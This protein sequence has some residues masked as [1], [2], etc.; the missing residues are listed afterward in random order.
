VL[1]GRAA[2]AV[3]APGGEG[4]G[5]APWPPHYAK[6]PGEPRA[7]RPRAEGR[8]GGRRVPTKP[9]LEIGGRARRTTRWPGSSAGR[10]AIPR[11]PP[12]PARRRARRTRCAGATR[13]GRASA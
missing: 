3:R 13:P 4:Q 11:R 10:R 12:S 2:G 5:D 8:P 1:A 9:L 7:W 6:Q